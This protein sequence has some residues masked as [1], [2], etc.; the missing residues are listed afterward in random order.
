MKTAAAPAMSSAPHVTV[1]VAEDGSRTS[2]SVLRCAVGEQIQF[3]MSSLQSYFFARWEPIAWDALL[4]AA[5]VEF[6]DKTQSRPARTWRRHFELRLPVHNP[7]HWNSTKV[8]S[9]LR[10]ALE[11]LTGDEWS[12]EFV[13]RRRKIER[14]EQISLSL[15]PDTEAVIPFSN[16]LDSCVVAALIQRQLGNKLVRIR[17]GTGRRD[18]KTLFRKKEAFTRIPY[19]VSSGKKPFVESSSRSRGFTFA[20]ISGLAAF[21]S[22][23]TRII[24]PESGQGA[25]GPSLVTVGQAGEDY[26]SH[27]LFTRKMETYLKALFGHTVTFEFPRIWN[28]KAETLREFVD[29]CKDASWLE[30]KSCWQQNRQS[31]VDGK[32]RHCGICAACMLRRMSV[33]GAGEKEPKETYV[34]ENL[35]AHRFEG[36]RR[37]FFD[38]DKITPAMRGI[39]D[40]R[41]PASRSFG[42][43]ARLAGKHPNH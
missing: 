15:D 20:T 35:S 19:D 13:Q 1:H 4:V 27:P 41:N 34:W 28:T 42:R 24:V 26:R 7:H 22:N 8:E 25:L 43:N 17:L 9:A 33:H 40:R 29:T 10:D 18:G 6:A 21:L 23:S 16:G 31:S 32:W 3:S 36:R 37:S 14:P 12:F 11:F 30:T 38:K 2:A 5:A 39:R